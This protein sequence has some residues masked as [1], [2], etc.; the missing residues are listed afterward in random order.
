MIVILTVTMCSLHDII[1]LQVAMSWWHSFVLS[2]GWSMGQHD[3]DRNHIH[4]LQKNFQDSWVQVKGNQSQPQQQTRQQI[5][6][7]HYTS[8]KI[9][10]PS[11]VPYKPQSEVWLIKVINIIINN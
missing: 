2:N 7:E 1:I 9:H 5:L 3:T 11:L 4:Y 6:P 8:Y 10:T